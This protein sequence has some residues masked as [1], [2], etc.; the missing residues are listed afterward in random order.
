MFTKTDITKM[1]A[2]SSLSLCCILVK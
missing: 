1:R 2:P